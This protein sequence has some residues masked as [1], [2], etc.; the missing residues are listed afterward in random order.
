MLTEFW[1]NLSYNEESFVTESLGI[2]RIGYS[3]KEVKSKNETLPEKPVLL[4]ACCSL[5]PPSHPMPLLNHSQELLKS[6][7]ILLK[8]QHSSETRTPSGGKKK[9]DRM[10][11]VENQVLKQARNYTALYCALQT[12]FCLARD[13]KAF[14]R[15]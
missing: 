12:L 13:H 10:Q 6:P 2:H 7:V 5:L 15:C 8:Q 3:S 9:R 11:L 1:E 4:S 14:E